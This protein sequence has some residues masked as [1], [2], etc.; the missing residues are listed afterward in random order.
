MLWG[1][2]IFTQYNN[3]TKHD[4]TLFFKNWINAGFHFV[5]S[6]KFINGALDE[7]YIYDKIIDKRNIYCEILSLKKA[8][9]PYK[10]ILRQLSQLPENNSLEDLKTI[11]NSFTTERFQGRFL[12]K[13]ISHNKMTPPYQERVW[14]QI[15]DVDTIDFSNLYLRK[16]KFM[17]DKKLAEFNFKVLH[18]IL[19]CGLNLNRWGKVENKLCRICKVTHDIPHLLFFC[20]K[21]ITV[22]NLIGNIFECDI[23][24]TDVI[25]TKMDKPMCML[26]SILGYLIYKDWLINS[27]KENWEYKSIIL[28]IKYELIG[29]IKVYEKL[30]FMKDFVQVMEK[31]IKKCITN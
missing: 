12:Y 20:T 31:V 15:L 1:N 3:R 4:E 16:I 28:Y 9:S 11:S 10:Y 26:I 14:L 18:L 2:V 21:A 30:D 17:P 7:T 22:W 23:S 25:I 8:L 19:A 5:K 13:H 24:L 6:L 27:M 29:K